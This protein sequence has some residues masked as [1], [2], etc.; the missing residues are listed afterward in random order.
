L[1]RI[2]ILIPVSIV[3]KYSRHP[4][5]ILFMFLFLFPFYL[6]T[7]CVI[8]AVKCIAKIASLPKNQQYLYILNVFFGNPSNQN[9]WVARESHRHH[10]TNNEDDMQ[11][12]LE[13]CSICFESK[14]DLCLDYCRDQFC[15]ECFHKFVL[16][17]H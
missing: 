11:Q 2:F 7:Q 6:L 5:S 16:F 4:I 15:L 12:W 10:H 8:Y 13:R 17:Y 9:A 1:F 3:K 14:L